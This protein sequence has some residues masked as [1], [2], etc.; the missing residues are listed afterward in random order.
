MLRYL[1]SHPNRPVSREKL[2]EIVWGYEDIIGST[3]TVDVYVRHIREK[4]EPEPAK[5]R[6]IVSVRG[7][8]Y[9]FQPE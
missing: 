6:W 5:P 7:L 3:R 9:K 8:E 1:V 4:I 2:I